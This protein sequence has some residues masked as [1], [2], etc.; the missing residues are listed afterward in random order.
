MSKDP[1][2]IGIICGG[3]SLERGI[4]LNSARS[5]IDHLYQVETKIY[6]VSQTMAVYVLS[7]KH[8]YSNTPDDF[9]FKLE[10]MLSPLS[11]DEWIADMQQLSM[12][13]PLIHGQYGED[14]T[15]Q[16]LLE[17]HGI[18][19]VGSGSVA[20]QTMFPKDIANRV[21]QLA[22]YPCLEIWK[23]DISLTQFLEK[24]TKV[25]VKPVAGGSSI[26]VSVVD[27]ERQYQSAVSRVEG[28][29]ICEAYC[30]GRE[31]TVV[32]L[33]HQGVPV[34]L[35]PTEIEILERSGGSQDIYDYRRK[36]LPTGNTRWHCPPRFEPE[37]VD[38]IREQAKAVFQL[39]QMQDFARLDGWV[40]GDDHQI[41]F[42]DLNPISG[43]E[44]NS[45]LFLQASRVGMTHQDVLSY[46]LQ[47]SAQRQG[48]C[49]PKGFQMEEVSNSD[50][51]TVLPVLMGGDSEERQVSLMSGTNV[52]LKLRQCSL[53]HP[54][55]Y[56]MDRDSRI[57]ALPYTYA[58]NHTVEEVY[59]LLCQSQSLAQRAEGLVNRIR[60]ELGLTPVDISTIYPV[61]HGRSIAEFCEAYQNQYVFLGLHG[62]I[63]ENG[64]LQ[65]R[66][67]SYGIKHNGAC[68]ALSRLGMDK[69]LFAQAVNRCGIPGVESLEKL[70]ITPDTPWEAVEDMV[71]LVLKPRF[72]GCSVGVAVITD[73]DSYSTYL[74]QFV[75][76]TKEAI[77]ESF[78]ITDK[79]ELSPDGK[80]LHQKS[81]N[82]WIELTL[83]VTEV[84]KSGTF[85]AHIPSLT[86]AK[87]DI[88]SIEEKFQ[89][90]TGINITPPSCLQEA[91]VIW[92][93]K[94]ISQ[95]ASTLGIKGYARFDLFY[96]IGC[97]E[98][99]VIEVNTL[100]ALTPSTV[101]FQQL[102]EN[103]IAKTPTGVLKHIMG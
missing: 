62:G 56:F 83:V 33:V 36:Y 53:T 49:L 37:V 72:G 2:C 64:E 59:D 86:V 103:G 25:V 15:L 76:K 31:F 18:A 32:V 95:L 80:Q 84:E 26:G 19:F 35:M 102:L 81:L 5:I 67:K 27:S 43:M 39:F 55:P 101:L 22:R 50:E 85:Q 94:G 13:M 51:V 87:S 65:A 79:F 91:E 69:Y 14:G 38:L 78:V 28:K 92:I 6:Y 11:Q 10:R 44:Q 45:F 77:A 29:A 74:Q 97:E 63:G 66:F 34:A 3:P 54:K 30:E 89:G 12:V 98:M 40:V 1:F 21:L 57:W 42:S 100:P 71:P 46:I 70:C 68:E 52:W 17:Q 75:S 90:G 24:H 47:Q 9:D 7:P 20:C 93:Q 23:E 4:S 73:K 99:I 82:G 58:L 41:I 60:E 48:V 96:Q 16:A 61:C 88:L 8:L